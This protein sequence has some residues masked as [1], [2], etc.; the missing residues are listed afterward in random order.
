MRIKLIYIAADKSVPRNDVAEH[1]AKFTKDAFDPDY[2]NGFFFAPQLIGPNI[3]H[4]E[5]KEQ[6]QDVSNLLQ[7][8]R[9]FNEFW[10]IGPDVTDDLFD[11]CF[12]LEIRS[13]KMDNKPIRRF[14]VPTAT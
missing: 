8:T 6:E 3:D 2:M 13:A 4:Y 14:K 5:T 10:L 1:I 7:F 12:R 9:R 11:R